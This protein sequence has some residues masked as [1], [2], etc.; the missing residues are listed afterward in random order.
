MNLIEFIYILNNNYFIYNIYYYIII[1]IISKL[2]FDFELK[3]GSINIQAE[4]SWSLAL[5]I[6]Y[7][8]KIEFEILRLNRIWVEFWDEFRA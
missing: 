7:Q 4:L 8:I 3:Y 1:C 6:F 2:R 5:P